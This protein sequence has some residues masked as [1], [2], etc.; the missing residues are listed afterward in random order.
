[1]GNSAFKQALVLAIQA[2]GGA[3]IYISRAHEVIIDNLTT[4]TDN[5]VDTLCDST[6]FDQ[7]CVYG[8][9]MAIQPTIRRIC[10]AGPCI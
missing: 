3:A 1:V 6:N 10:I 8:V 5:V 9:C 4:F 2:N 7:Y